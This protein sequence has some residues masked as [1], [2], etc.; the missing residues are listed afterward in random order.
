[1]VIVLAIAILFST[2][3]KTPEEKKEKS[4]SEAVET[5]VI[6]ETSF[7]GD[8][9]KDYEKPKPR[10]NRPKAKE[11]QSEVKEP[12]PEM[13]EP[14]PEMKE[15]R[16]E[17]KSPCECPEPDPTVRFDPEDLPNIESDIT[18]TRSNT[19]ESVMD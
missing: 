9:V 14:R 7:D 3:L 12:S 8:T 11:P 13:K 19:P 15:P 18:D 17:K 4:A 1:M 6:D 10:P 2:L 5:V 16:P